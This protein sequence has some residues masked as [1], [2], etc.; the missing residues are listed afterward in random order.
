MDIDQAYNAGFEDGRRQGYKDAVE[1]FQR[2]IANLRFDELC[3]DTPITKLNGLKPGTLNALRRAGYN[4]V[5]ELDLASAEDRL[6]FRGFGPQGRNEV[7]RA[8]ATYRAL[9]K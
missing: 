1:H 9:R 8:L 5:G 7:E 3:E 4:T 6:R 2:L